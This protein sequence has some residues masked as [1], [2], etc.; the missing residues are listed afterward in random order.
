MR[1]EMRTT[2]RAKKMKMTKILLALNLT[3]FA[4]LFLAVNPGLAHTDQAPS[5]GH[6]DHAPI[7]SHGGDHSQKIPG[8]DNGMKCTGCSLKYKDKAAWVKEQPLA[9]VGDFVKCPVSGAIFEVKEDSKF[10]MHE[11]KK[12]YTCCGACALRAGKEPDKFVKT[13]KSSP[14]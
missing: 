9:K 5:V 12:Y 4:A 8:T 11:G 7:T 2:M 14:L 13:A 1:A 10:I 6:R 3:I